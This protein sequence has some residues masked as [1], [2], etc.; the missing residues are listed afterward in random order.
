MSSNSEEAAEFVT[1]VR[2]DHVKM[3]E[4]YTSSTSSE[5]KGLKEKFGA[6]PSMWK[7]VLN[8]PGW[9]EARKE[10]LKQQ[11]L[12]EKSSSDPIPRKRKSRWGSASSTPATSDPPKRF[13]AAPPPSQAPRVVLPNLPG[14]NPN[15]TPQQQTELRIMQSK[16]RGVN[17]RLDNLEKEA[18]RVDELPRGHRERS[19]SPPPSKYTSILSEVS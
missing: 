7:E 15:L 11:Q 5:V 13:A 4:W 17:E 12:G 3:K 8:W 16:L 14:M 1:T 2:T 6:Y 10:Y 9:K 19:P 18:A